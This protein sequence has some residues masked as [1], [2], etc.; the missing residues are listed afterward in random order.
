MFA[1]EKLTRETQIA[2]EKLTREAQDK[3]NRDQ[4]EDFKKEH[5]IEIEILSDT[6]EKKL[7]E[8]EERH[9][10]EISLIQKQIE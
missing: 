9:S 1:Q 3:L 4:L 10:A 8:M 2:E 7:I 5:K 6:F